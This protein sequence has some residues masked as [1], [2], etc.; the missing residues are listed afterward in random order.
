MA[1][2][3]QPP[4]PVTGDAESGSWAVMDC[5]A[6]LGWLCPE[7]AERPPDGRGGSQHG[8]LLSHLHE[9]GAAHGAAF[10]SLC[11][12]LPRG[13]WE[14]GWGCA[15]FPPLSPA[16]PVQL[17]QASCP[18]PSC[19]MLAP[20]TPRGLRAGHCH[21][22]VVWLL[23]GGEGSQLP[24]SRLLP[25]SCLAWAP[26]VWRD[27]ARVLEHRLSRFRS[28]G[29]SPRATENEKQPVC[30]ISEYLVNASWYIYIPLEP[31]GLGGAPGWLP[32]VYEPPEIICKMLPIHGFSGGVCDPP[33]TLMSAEQ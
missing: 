20:T 9:E 28:T 18:G 21:S 29:V 23:G 24:A 14:H 8:G 7:K 16:L 30:P 22:W 1:S 33:Q 3:P 17:S 15:C 2:P 5:Y 13:Q 31:G 12:V 11:S 27:T 32:G 19:P 6:L 4:T 26:W 10:H 25:E